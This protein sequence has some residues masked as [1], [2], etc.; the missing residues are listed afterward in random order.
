[1]ES[2][3]IERGYNKH[4]QKALTFGLFIIFMILCFLPFSSHSQRT[5]IGS[6]SDVSLKNEVQNAIGRGLTW[7]SAK[8]APEGWWSQQEHPALTALPLTAFQGDPSGFY[9]RKYEQTIDKG[10]AFLLKSVKPD[11]G[12]YGNGLANYNTSVS[13]MALYVS[14]RPEYENVIRRARNFLVGLQDDQRKKGNPDSPLDGGVGYGGTYPHSD[15]SNTTLA[16]EALYYTRY[17]EKEVGGDQEIKQLNW[18]AAARFITRCQNLPGSND[19]KWASDD[20]QN[21]GGFVYFPGKSQAGEMTLPDGKV[22]L[23]SY[24]SMSYAGLLSYIYAQL[25][26]EDPRVKEVY[27]WLAKSYTLD[28]NPGMGKEGLYYYYH[29]MAKA[30]SAYGAQRLVLK[31][32]REVNWRTDLTKRLLDLQDG[33]GFW[34]NESGRW[35]EK[36]P[37]L[38]TSYAVLTLEIIWRGL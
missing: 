5:V 25:D 9:K 35:W 18:Q 23:R 15:L 36:D 26:K 28:E 14:N 11:G 6:T 2:K 13:V 37:V 1:M 8:Q 30:L 16:L 32:G 27:S 29:T 17:L 3:K 34:V 24:G 38:V 20:P 12:I 10:Y 7:L 22:A 33:E 31:D 19:Q 4:G 21:K